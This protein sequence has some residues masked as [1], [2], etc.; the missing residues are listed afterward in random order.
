[1]RLKES[2]GGVKLCIQEIAM[3]V[4]SLPLPPLPIFCPVLGRRRLTVLFPDCFEQGTRRA[5][6]PFVCTG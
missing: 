6:S 5:A 4:V 2:V 3:N 1:M